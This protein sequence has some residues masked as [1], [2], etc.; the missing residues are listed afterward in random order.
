MHP[1]VGAAVSLGASIVQRADAAS[2]ALPAVASHAI[3]SADPGP[4]VRAQESAP[5]EG[6][7]PDQVS[8]KGLRSETA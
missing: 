8:R 7:G 2:R 5:I 3:G 1:V 6:D 4:T